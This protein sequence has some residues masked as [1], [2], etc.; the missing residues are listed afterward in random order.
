[1]KKKTFVFIT[2]ISLITFCSNFAFSK[3]KENLT[4]GLIKSTLESFSL[5]ARAPEKEAK[6]DI[7]GY[8][9]VWQRF[10]ATN[11]KNLPLNV[12]GFSGGRT[13]EFATVG[14]SPGSGFGMRGFFGDKSSFN[15]LGKFYHKDEQSYFTGL[16]LGRIIRTQTYVNRFLHRFNHDP[17]TNVEK[18]AEASEEEFMWFEDQNPKDIYSA[19]RTEII[20][21]TD[22]VIPSFPNLKIISQVRYVHKNGHQQARTFD[23]CY[24]CHIVAQTQGVDQ[25]TR[26][27]ILGAELKAKGVVFSYSHLGRQFESKANPLYHDYTDPENIFLFKGKQEFAHIPNSEKRADTLKAK[28]DAVKNTSLFGSYTIS[29]IRNKN[30][31]G[32]AGIKNF[33]SRFRALLV[34]GLNITLRYSNNK[35]KNTTNPNYI[36]TPNNITVAANHLSKKSYTFGADAYYRI[37]K[38]RINLI[39]GY[40][41]NNLKRSFNWSTEENEEEIDIMDKYLKETKTNKFRLGATF[42][43]TSKIKG[44]L[45]YKLK[46]IKNP[47]GTPITAEENPIDPTT[48]RFMSSLYTNISLFSTGIS[49]IPANRISLSANYFFNSSK[50]DT[51]NSSQKFNNLIFSLWYGVSNKISL[52]ASYTYVNTKTV[53]TFIFYIEENRDIPY[54]KKANVFLVA[55]DLRP[56]DNFSIFGDISATLGKSY[57]TIKDSPMTSNVPNFS[58]QDLSHYRISAGANYSFMKN[59]SFFGKWKYE[60]YKDR[61][62]TLYAD[63][64]KYSIF[65]FGFG[66]MF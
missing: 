51:I 28:V 8:V 64:G 6:I 36:N 33:L 20:N 54:E 7:S 15:L 50:N 40:E 59:M 27:F 65:Y 35:Y 29:K 49:F 42:Y 23:N 48:D 53:N 31:N 12:S 17:L 62:F 30:N 56:S 38:Q 3:E 1:M 24:G 44:F 26:D 4:T 61:A 66:Y 11:T 52:T 45:R 46:N 13:A 9:S 39:A 5:A 21:K 16:D 57:W 41:F 25:K 18:D 58:N 2:I 32:E 43:P 63:S 47:L 55:I 10:L 19:T 60:D 37:P 22:L 34:K 14:S